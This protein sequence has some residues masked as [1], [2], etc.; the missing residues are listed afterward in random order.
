VHDTVSTV[1]RVSDNE[2]RAGPNHPPGRTGT[3][4]LIAQ[5]VLT[6]LTQKPPFSTAKPS[7]VHLRRA[8]A[9]ARPQAER[10]IRCTVVP[11]ASPPVHRA[12]DERAWLQTVGV[13]PLKAAQILEAR[14]NKRRN[15]REQTIRDIDSDT[16][17]AAALLAISHHQWTICEADKIL[18][19]THQSSRCMRTTLTLDDDVAAI[20]ERL[21]K[22]RDASLKDL[23]N[24]ALRRGLKDMITRTKP[25]ERLQTRSV[26]LGR[27]QIANL[28]NIADALAVAEG[29]AYK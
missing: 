7:D 21:R 25:R 4:A 3:G 11:L 1:S 6:V 13:S 16:L 29:E 22:S 20:L 18:A 14:V 26:A 12:G 27:L 9:G 5:T 17:S 8:A 24:E 23:V 2:Y 15:P 10:R 28:D 19:S